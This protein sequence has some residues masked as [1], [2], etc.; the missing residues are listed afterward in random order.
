MTRMEQK[1]KSFKS[2]SLIGSV[3]VDKQSHGRHQR[4]RTWMKTFLF[5]FAVG[6]LF[7]LFFCFFSIYANLDLRIS[8]SILRVGTLRRTSKE[9]RCV[10]EEKTTR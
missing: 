1:Q 9:K 5:F 7:D 8:S 3:V 4:R 10:C 6:A 2:D